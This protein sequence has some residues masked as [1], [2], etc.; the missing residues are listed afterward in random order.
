L[1]GNADEC[2]E[3][4]ELGLKRAPDLLAEGEDA[5]VGDPVVDVSAMFAAGEHARLDEYGEVLEAFCCL[6]PSCSASV[7]TLS[8]RSRSRSRMRTRS[9]SLRARKRRA[10]SSARSS[11]PLSVAAGPLGAGRH[12]VPRRGVNSVK[13]RGSTTVAINRPYA[14][15]IAV[16]NVSK[17]AALPLTE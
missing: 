3:G 9:G 17:P 1:G 16:T 2:V 13:R 10:I 6:A 15:E 11:G 5:L 7:L 14:I 12:Q 8:S 4:G